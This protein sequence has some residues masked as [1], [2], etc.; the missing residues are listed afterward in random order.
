MLAI[1]ELKGD[2]LSIGFGNDGLIR[3]RQFVMGK[4]S[5]VWM[6]VLKRVKP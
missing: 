3:P 2:D 1:Y 6:L 4:E 5:V